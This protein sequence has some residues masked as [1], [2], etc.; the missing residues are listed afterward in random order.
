M[1]SEPP[2][3]QNELM[4]LENTMTGLRRTVN[5]MEEKLSK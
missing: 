3:T 5:A 2:I 4:M 1:L